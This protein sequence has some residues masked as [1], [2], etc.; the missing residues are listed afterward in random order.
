MIDNKESKKIHQN[1]FVI[2]GTLELNNAIT[3][4][5]SMF[6]SGAGSPIAGYIGILIGGTKYKL[7]LYPWT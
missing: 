4:S 2:N 1:N 3:G 5:N 7:P 6:I